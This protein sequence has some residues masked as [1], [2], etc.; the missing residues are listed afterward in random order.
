MNR[1]RGHTLVELLVTMSVGGAL[2]LLATGVVHRTMRLESSSHQQADVHRTAVRL[3]HDFRQDAHRAKS[4]Q[5]SDLAEESTT[6]QFTLPDEEPVT[7]TLA[8]NM[9]LREQRLAEGQ[10]RR[11]PYYLPPGYQVAFT[12]EFRPRRAVLTLDYDHRLVGEAPQPL[13][14]VEAELGRLLRLAQFEEPTP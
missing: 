4:L 2:L 3:S 12:Q 5:L 9:V 7:Y 8:K 13:V 1:P 14:R 11:E 10:V 6:I